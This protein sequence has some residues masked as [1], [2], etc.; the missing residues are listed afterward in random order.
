MRFRHTQAFGDGLRIE[1]GELAQ[2][3]AMIKCAGVEKIG[4][5]A[6][7][8]GLEFAKAYDAGI[9]AKPDEILTGIGHDKKA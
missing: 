3:H 2:R 5:Q 4:G 6:P 1:F 9:H 8:F 7:R